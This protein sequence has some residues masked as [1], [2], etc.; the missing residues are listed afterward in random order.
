VAYAEWFFLPVI[1]SIRKVKALNQLFLLLVVPVVGLNRLTV[2]DRMNTCQQKAGESSHYNKFSASS[3][4]ITFREWL[5][6][7]RVGPQ[8]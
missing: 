5:R 1:D 2:F 3:K 6:K 7:F 8:T 4:T